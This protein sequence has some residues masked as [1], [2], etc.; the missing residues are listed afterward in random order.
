MPALSTCAQCYISVYVF[1]TKLFDNNFLNALLVLLPKTKVQTIW[2]KTLH[3]EYMYYR[4]TA[5]GNGNARM[6]ESALADPALLGKL[7]DMV[8]KFC[9]KGKFLFPLD[10]RILSLLTSKLPAQRRR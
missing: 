5:A 1:Y 3:S 2:T 8:F 4:R 9:L 6:L 10:R 7:V